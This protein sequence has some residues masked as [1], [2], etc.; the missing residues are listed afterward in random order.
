M[1]ALYAGRGLGRRGLHWAVKLDVAD[2]FGS[3]RNDQIIEVLGDPRLRLHASMRRLGVSF[4]AANV[5]KLE[6]GWTPMTGCIYP[7]SV[8]GPLLANLVAAVKLDQPFRRSYG[9]KLG[10]VALRYGDDILV[11]GSTKQDANH[12]RDLLEFLAGEAGWRLSD[13]K[14]MGGAVDLRETSVTF[15]GK[16]LRASGVVTPQGMVDEFIDRIRSAEGDKRFGATGSLVYEL[17][18]DS[19]ERVDEIQGTLRG[20]NLGL[21]H[22]FERSRLR[23]A[24]RRRRRLAAAERILGKLSDNLG[25]KPR[26]QVGTK[27]AAGRPEP[28]S[29]LRRGV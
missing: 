14:T 28:K 5:F 2:F 1:Q 13:E 24:E 25:T 20:F 4:Q 16:S 11:L 7:G 21:E 12:G 27:A 29:G 22:G 15:L 3:V 8:A 17:S 26:R 18:L 6:G 23:Q 19:L 9:S 10:V